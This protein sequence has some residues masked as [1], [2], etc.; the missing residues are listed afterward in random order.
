MT[1]ST[2]LSVTNSIPGNGSNFEPDQHSAGNVLIPIGVIGLILL[3]LSL[4]SDPTILTLGIF[5]LVAAFPAAYLVW[6]RPELALL[7][8]IFLESD[9]VLPDQLLDLRVAGGGLDLRDI[10]LLGTVGLTFV[11]QLTHRRIRIPLFPIGGFLILFLLLTAVSLANSLVFENVAFNWAMNDF[12][13]MLY[14]TVFFATAWGITTHK[15]VKTFLIGMFV[16]ANLVVVLMIFQQILGID[17]LLTPGMSRWQITEEA[18]GSLRILPPLIFMI[19]ILMLISFAYA[20]YGSARQYRIIAAVQFFILLV[21]YLLTFTRS[22]WL[23]AFSAILIVLIHVAFQNRKKAAGILLLISPLFLS[24]L[25]LLFTVPITSYGRVPVVG[26]ML[27]RAASIFT[28]EETTESDS[29][30]WRVYENTEA[31]RSISER[32][33]FGVGLGNQ[34]REITIAQGEAAGHRTTDDITRLTRYV[35][36]SMLSIAVKMGLPTL[37]LFLGT[38]IYFIFTA[39]RLHAKFR[40]KLHKSVALGVVAV[41]IPALFWAQFFSLF[42]ESN[43]IISV[44]IFMGLVSIFYDF[45]SGEL[46]YATDEVEDVTQL[47]AASAKT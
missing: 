28:V 7:V 35:H 34:Y 24:I 13:I 44:A 33:I 6:H 5:G 4:I 47:D 38:Y 27:D 41:F 14:Y 45:H 30:Q 19:A 26:F 10:V 31:L 20:F 29:L 32:P 23:T 11:K 12:R 37:A 42:S 9:I 18:G 2:E 25:V 16:M 17:N 43:H 46:P 8:L 40:N 3:G 22:A 15:Q 36:N 1:T 21:G 39:W